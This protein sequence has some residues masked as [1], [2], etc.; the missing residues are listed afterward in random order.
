L[1]TAI[2]NGNKI[3]TFWD[4][5][6]KGANAQPRFCILTH[7]ARGED[8]T[9]VFLWGGGGRGNGKGENKNTEG[10]EF[11]HLGNGELRQKFQNSLNYLKLV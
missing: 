2:K 8:C 11:V 9:T 1:L 5:F 6:Y 7:C 4:I 3:L 10:L